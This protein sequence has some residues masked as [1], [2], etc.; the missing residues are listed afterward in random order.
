MYSPNIT[1]YAI[2][3]WSEGELIRAITAGVNKNEDPLFPIM[4]YKIYA[5]L[6]EEDL[7][8]IVAFVRSLKPIQHTPPR[9]KLKFPLNL[10]V[11]TIP[12]PTPPDRKIQSQPGNYLANIAGCIDCHTPVN[13]RGQH[14]PGMELAGGQKFGNVQSANITPDMETGIGK[15]SKADFIAAFRK[16][17]DP[18]LQ[19]IVM[20]E[21][22]NTVM[23][24]I[25]F[26]KM[27]EED[28]SEIYD[29][30]RTVRPINNKV[31]RYFTENGKE[32]ATN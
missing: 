24:W 6:K 30:L 18:A 14:L 12:G 31:E 20:P 25:D 26:S 28:L 32:P 19:K 21:N 27:K 11:R 8:S 9:T 13:D 15:W 4:P 29:Y 1:P 22:Q 2:G 23:P 10:I 7:Y 5:D 3:D 16:W 17:Q